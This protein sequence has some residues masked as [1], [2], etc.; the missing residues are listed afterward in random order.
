[1]NRIDLKALRMQILIDEF[2]KLHVIVNDQKARRGPIGGRV[3]FGRYHAA[4][5]YPAR[6]PNRNGRKQRKW[7]FGAPA[8]RRA[9]ALWRASS[10][11]MLNEGS[12]LREP[13][14]PFV[15][16]AMPFTTAHLS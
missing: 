15:G 3:C 4:S 10:C 9:R 7:K 2:A 5:L 13:A 12:L 11:E 8:T 6:G 16:A 14:M 1:M